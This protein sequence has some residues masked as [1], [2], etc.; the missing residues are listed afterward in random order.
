MIKRNVIISTIKPLSPPPRHLLQIQDNEVIQHLS[1]LVGAA[2]DIEKIADEN[3]CGAGTGFGDRA[4]GV[5][6][7]PDVGAGVK[8]V[9][10]VGIR[11]SI[12][13]AAVNY[14]D[15]V[16]PEGGAVATAFGWW[17]RRVW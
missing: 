10:I 12:G 4:P 1:V 3:D 13:F 9:D 17:G 11:S 16:S 8:G 5:E 7:G 15:V 2:A 6:L 14:D